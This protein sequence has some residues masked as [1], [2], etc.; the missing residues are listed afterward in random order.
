[1]ALTRIFDI[2]RRSLATYQNAMN[3]S[4]HNIAN[5][6]NSSYS[7]QKVVL[8][9][10]DPE[11]GAKFMWG[12][13]VKIATIE[14]VRD[15]LID[16]QMIN[17]QYA[18]SGNEKQS[19]IL[20]Q[21]EQV[22][23]EPS[24]LGL[25]SLMTEFF[26]SW[27]QLAV[28][29]NSIPLRNDVVVAA[30]NLSSRVEGINNDIDTIKYDI[31]SEMQGQV[32]SLNYYLKEI[33]G[34]NQQ[35][36]QYANG[37]QSANDLLD[38]RS[39][40]ID[41]LSKLANISVTYDNY[42][43]ATISV[44]G[45][46]AVDASVNIEFEVINDGGELYVGP[47]NS[48]AAVNLKGGELFAL[49]ET[50]SE[51]IPKYQ[52]Y[53]DTLFKQLVDSVNSVHSTGSTIESTP[54][55]GI[56]FFKEYKDG[57]LVIDDEILTDVKN[58]AVSSD[59]TDGNG[60]LAAQLGALSSNKV[61]SGTTFEGYYN[62]LISEVGNDKVSSDRLAEASKLVVEQ[63]ENQRASVS[64][65]SVDEEMTDIIKFQRSYDASARLIKIANEMLDTLMSL[66]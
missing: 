19:L 62:S 10:E 45:V 59:G 14:R 12:T 9:T 66:V 47:V 2:S 56:N 65:V 61:I 1:M 11:K 17:N 25:S 58:I 7:R 27:D 29:P 60:D 21:L 55:T 48:G 20:S 52:N 43:N 30:K 46:F 6:A 34:L 4:A 64:G 36:N 49:T 44:G 22:F 13:G 39:N 26:N 53:I 31:F 8:G 41:E 3:V 38:S 57:K 15:T 54:R 63:L 50:Y 18:Y 5:A 16:K 24:D 51:T 23:S 28:T 33:R 32:D 37:T 42:D 40:M 35:I